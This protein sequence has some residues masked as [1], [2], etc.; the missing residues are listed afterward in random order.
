MVLLK[1]IDGLLGGDFDLDGGGGRRVGGAQKRTPAGRR[2][3]EAQA[4][5]YG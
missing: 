5:S 2:G 4:E 1:K 3:H